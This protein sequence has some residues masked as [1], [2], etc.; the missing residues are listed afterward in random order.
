MPDLPPPARL[1][2]GVV[3]F[4][5]SRPLAWGLRAGHHADRLDALYL[6]P[7]EIA[8]R[9]AAGTLDVGLVPSIEVPRIGGLEVLPDACVAA[10]Q[11]V[12]SVLLVSRR[13]LPEVRRVA[14]DAGSRTSA[15][16]TRILAAERWGIAPAYLEAP[17]DVPAMLARADAALVIGDP[18]LRVDRE[19]WRVVDL[20][21]EWQALTGLP[22]VFAVWAAR[23]AALAAVPD[24]AARLAASLRFGL[25]RLD[26][27]IAQAVRDLGLPAG[28]VR[29]Y[30][31]EALDFELGPRQ[32]AGLDEFWRRARA[33][34]LIEAPIAV[35]NI[36]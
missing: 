9:L 34:G 4:L 23:P 20:A 22:F 31:T 13:P 28:L 35:A 8:R 30:L 10:T 3:D 7:A 33:H 1:R 17:A 36:C 32:R 16:L 29:A 11:E 25:D 2:V 24:L 5:N 14:L 12:R 15:A 21:A 18:A 19:R 27:V 6:P 26:E